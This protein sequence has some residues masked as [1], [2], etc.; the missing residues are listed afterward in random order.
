[1]NEL[2][3]SLKK[4]A[5]MAS[6]Y[7]DALKIL[8]QKESSVKYI[9]HHKTDTFKVSRK[10]NGLFKVEVFNFESE[11]DV[12]RLVKCECPQRK[13]EPQRIK[14]RVGNKEFELR[15]NTFLPQMFSNLTVHQAVWVFYF[16]DIPHSLDICTEEY[17]VPFEHVKYIVQKIMQLPLHL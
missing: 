15:A 5:V 12:I 17:L 4:D 13:I 9:T 11:S 8:A 14:M 6:D 3:S 10:A 16:W 2:A 1:M 7:Q